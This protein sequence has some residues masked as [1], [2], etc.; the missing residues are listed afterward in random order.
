MSSFLIDLPECQP[1]EEIACGLQECGRLRWW[2]GRVPDRRSRLGRWHPLPAVLGI[3]VCALTRAGTESATAIGQWVADCSQATLAALGCRWDPFLRQYRPPSTRTICRVLAEGDIEALEAAVHGYLRERAGHDD[4]PPELPHAVL[5]EREQRRARAAGEHRLGA[6]GGATGTPLLEACAADGKALRGARRADGSQV[7]LLSVMRHRDGIVTAQREIHAKTNEIPELE[8]AIEH[9]DLAG[10][11][12]TL[13]A[14]HTQR[15]TA[16]H[17]VEAKKAHYLMIVKG[18][19]PTLGQAIAAALTGTDQQFAAT[20]HVSSERGHGRRERRTI[21]TA[22][23][24][25][26]DWPHAGQIFR[27]RRDTGELNGPWTSKE[28]VYGITDLI[29]D[30]AGPAQIGTC[31]RQHWGIENKIHYIRDVTF[32]ED[33]S[34]IRTGHLPRAL[35][36]IR[37]LITGTLRLAGHVNIAHA[38]RHYGHD[39]QRLLDLYEFGH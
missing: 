23:A 27:I 21:R 3:A 30:Q 16:A 7:M 5:A 13:D 39:D 17:L 8:P 31:A 6:A 11:V 33:A 25:G 4:G 15:D 19:Q 26:I 9:L 32:G 29:P 14:L 38:R 24:T 22:P 1:G 36:T 2:L 37:N 28:I 20:T 18:N 35:A 34:Q 10:Q 12:L